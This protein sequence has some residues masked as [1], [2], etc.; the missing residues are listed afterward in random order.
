VRA[1][2]ALP[3]ERATTQPWEHASAAPCAAREGENVRFVVSVPS[4]LDVTPHADGV[5]AASDPPPTLRPACPPF[6]LWW[7]VASWRLAAEE[8]APR[9]A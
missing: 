4:P 2:F 8:P 3:F 6:V 9:H 1:I 5:R 7:L